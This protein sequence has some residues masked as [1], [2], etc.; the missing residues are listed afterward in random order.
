MNKPD[1]L[2]K[3]LTQWVPTLAKNP[4]KLTLLVEDGHVATRVCTAGLGYE[5]RYTLSVLIT[6]FT[7]PMDTLVVP[8]ISWLH[9]AQPDLLLNLEKAAKAIKF[10]AE[11]L[12]NDQTDL[13]IKLDLSEGVR[14]TPQTGGG[15]TCEHL[16]EPALPDLTGPTGWQMFINGDLLADGIA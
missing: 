10:Q 13:L 15:Y 8:I 16:A 5:Y 11:F 6:E 3:I 14:V 1:E 9:T 2:R 4:E 7:D 12:N